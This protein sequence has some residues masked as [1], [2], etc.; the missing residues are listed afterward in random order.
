MDIVLL[1]LDDAAHDLAMAVC[2]LPEAKDSP[3]EFSKPSAFED[4]LHNGTLDDKIIKGPLTIPKALLELASRI[5]FDLGV[6]QDRPVYDFQTMM[7]HVGPMAL[8][9]DCPTYVS[10]VVVKQTEKKGRGL[11]ARKDFKRGEL[12][13]LEKAFVLP[14]YFIAD[15]SSDCLLYNLGSETASLRPGALLFKELLQKLRHNPSCR[16][17]FFELDSGG[18]PA[19]IKPETPD[20][21]IPV[22]V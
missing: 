14:G 15:R 13:M 19:A 4:W 7:A 9:L 5:K 12:L 16:R 20:E 21:D 1:R 22:D 18:Y 8:H 17:E 6:F 3:S 2:S 10:D 11:F